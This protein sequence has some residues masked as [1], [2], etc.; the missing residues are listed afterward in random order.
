VQKL[1]AVYENLT[2]DNAEDWSNAVHSCRRILQDLADAIYP[3]REDAVIEVG[4]KP[5]TIKLGPDN[6]A[7]RIIAFLRENSQSERFE[8][9][10]GSHLSYIG[11]R[12][13]SVFQAAQKGSHST[14]TRDEADR[15]VVYTYL[16]VGDV[17]SLL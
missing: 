1:S 12:L 8:A 17:L 6:Y 11:E 2:S 5:K 10:V 9:I 7:N 14:V 15:Y 4:G 16:V 13:D 3:Q